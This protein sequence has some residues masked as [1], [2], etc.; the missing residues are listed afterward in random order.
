MRSIARL[1]GSVFALLAALAGGDAL[2]QAYPSKTVTL[3]VPYA[4]GGG[5]DAMARIVAEK[6]GPRLGQTVVVENKPGA[7]GM[8]GTEQV[9]RA[10]PDGYTL[11]FSSPAE[12]VVAPSVYRTMRYDPVRDLTPITQVGDTP[13]VLMAHPSVG[14]KTVAELIA[15]AKKEPGKLSFGTAGTGSSQ[16]LAGAWINNLAGIDLQHVP[17]KGAGPATNDLLG[18][19]VPLGILG[20]APVLKHIQAG[21]IVALAVMTPKRVDW[22][23]DTPTVAETPGMEGFQANHWMGLLGPAGMPPEV[24]AK[25]QGE[26]A[27]VLAMPEVR[28]RLR[29][30]G[31][32]P[33]G[34]STEDFR[35]FLAEERERFAKMFRL[36]GLKQE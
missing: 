27:A 16:H 26:V 14:V 2:A 19:N 23:K 18:G 33:V 29:G 36:T 22:A 8:I 28:E 30:L 15:K 5:H 31:I 32:D 6:L 12:I 21:R 11:L 20:M 25:L 34:S 1:L 3:L 17:Y 13:L 10:A 35:R 7:A 9:V 24:V 4:P